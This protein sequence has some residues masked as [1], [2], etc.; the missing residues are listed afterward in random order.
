MPRSTLGN[1]RGVT[2]DRAL[3]LYDPTA[4]GVTSA[5]SGNPIPLAST[6]ILEFHA[7]INVQPY[8]GFVAGTAYW[9]ITIEIAD[10]LA[11]PYK[12]VGTVIAVGTQ[13]QFHLPLS[14]P[15][16]EDIDG[17]AYGAAFIRATATP[18]GSPGALQFGCFLAADY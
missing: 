9:S 15:W 5:T 18:T 6:R 3:Q 16:I 2:F 12:S 11:G 4:P 14:G 13:N 10:A 8:T 7:I 1:R 17:A